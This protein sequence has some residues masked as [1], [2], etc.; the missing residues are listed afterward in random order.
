MNV[1]RPRLHCPL[2]RVS[3]SN[4]VAPRGPTNEVKH[5]PRGLEEGSRKLRSSFNF[6]WSRCDKKNN[7][8]CKHECQSLVRYNLCFPAPFRFPNF[9][10]N[11]LLNVAIVSL[12]ERRSGQSPG[13]KLDL[14]HYEPKY[15]WFKDAY[16]LFCV[17][18][19]TFSVLLSTIRDRATAAQPKL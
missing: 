15:E 6:L 7:H 18:E 9:R 1:R 17:A 3:V 19:K 14:A 13:A 2:V 4:H 5:Y 10:P 8:C 16:W 12:R 11:L